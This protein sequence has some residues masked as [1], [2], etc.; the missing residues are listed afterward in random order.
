[1]KIEDSYSSLIELLRKMYKDGIAEEWA[2]KI[3]EEYTFKYQNHYDKKSYPLNGGRRLKCE[4]RLINDNKFCSVNIN[5]P[6]LRYIN[7]NMLLGDKKNW[8]KDRSYMQEKLVNNE[9]NNLDLDIKNFFYDYHHGIDKINDYCNDLETLK[10]PKYKIELFYR[11]HKI[12]NSLLKSIDIEESIF[13]LNII[14][15]DEISIDWESYQ[16]ADMS[17]RN[18]ILE[19][20][21]TIHVKHV[22]IRN[23]EEQKFIILP[24]HYL[25]YI[26]ELFNRNN[27]IYSN[28]IT[29]DYI[30]KENEHN[31]LDF[32]IN[33]NDNKNQLFNNKTIV[34][35]SYEYIY[36]TQ[37]LNIKN[38]DFNTGDFL[39]ICKKGALFR[40][41]QIQNITNFYIRGN[42]YNILKSNNTMRINSLLQGEE[43]SDLLFYHTI[44]YI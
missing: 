1:M 11:R 14:N 7:Q 32:N 43:F 18:K 26:I 4:I 19:C 40:R 22:K 9:F 34:L 8:K 6:Q 15:K 21:L 38:I 12:I 25:K 24:Y 31:F 30:K 3:T 42:L 41:N 27:S 28:D 36:I 35:E 5:S 2:F 37:I 44:T 33:Y 23:E 20:F 39:Y 13:K 29:L 16:F 10:T 17:M